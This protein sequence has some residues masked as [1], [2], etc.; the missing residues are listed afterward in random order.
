MR[1][2]HGRSVRAGSPR[3]PR[4]L[5]FALVVLATMP[6][7]GTGPRAEEASTSTSTSASVA[8]VQAQATL[9]QRPVLATTPAPRAAP[10]PAPIAAPAD[11]KDLP[12]W[13]DYRVRNHVA[14]LPLEARHFYRQGLLLHE[15]GKAEDA[16][17]Y[18]RGA[19]E[20]DPGFVAP[21]LTLASWLMLREPSQALLQYATVI[22]LAR[23][24]FLFQLATAGN[25]L[26]L[27]LVALF[28]G[29][30]G[31][32]LLVVALRNHELRHA[33]AER[34]ARRGD[35]ATARW[36]AWGLLLLPFACGLGLALPTLALL[37]L[38]RPSLR[39]A[40]RAVLFGL[41]AVVLALP[42]AAGSL[43]RLAV[44]LG[45]A[46]SPF[47]GVPLVAAETPTPERRAQLAA[48]AA[49]H[50]D[51]P[52]LQVAAAWTARR[53]GD[54][55]AAEAG[56]RR[57]L[58]LW[59]EDDRVLNNLGNV[60]AMQGRQ[61]EALELY[62]HAGRVNPANAAAPFN[63]SQI[64][65]QR[66]DYHAATDALSR[67]SA[68]DFDLV[69]T[70]QSQATDDGV[71]PLADEWIAPG[72]F[73]AALAPRPAAPTSRG[74]LPPPWAACVEC[75]GWGFGLAALLVTALALLL[76]G[77]LGRALPL[78]ACSNCGAVV[79]RRCARRRRETAL[80]P[81]CAAA[82][83]RADAPDFARVL[84]HNRR[85]QVRAR[86]RYLQTAVAL[87]VPGY[88]LLAYR[89]VMAP[90]LLLCAGGALLAL[91]FGEAAPFWYEARPSL[92][93]RHLPAAALT[94]AWLLLCAVSFLGYL[95]RR[96]RADADEA[97]AAAP[98]R[99]RIRLSNRDRS[100][101]AA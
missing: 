64:Y 13:L 48:L 72:S 87:L 1:L 32:G 88:G 25:A 93:S 54:L 90:V 24:D 16:V 70:Y 65:T 21:H 52:F 50:A 29:L 3:L 26:H 23:D 20:L 82:E 7:A 76:G 63:A 18:V 2:R 27:A 60:L 68:L 61:D 83:A 95:A 37:A 71:L 99:S 55:A 73:W 9:P 33:W 92:T 85:R 39:A 94:G 10:P 5:A 12:A 8:P 31:T 98:V 36:W 67:A 58:G 97:A 14:A 84:L 53:G 74:A 15:D 78:R 47:H 30:L 4:R 46:H 45:D 57:A 100:T 81:A 49:T 38:L 6:P 79:C 91:T 22:E 77:R 66:F 19:A 75:S 80:C 11:L 28:V 51:S 101:L 62:R 56:Y 42:W 86:R 34:L 17:R 44:P 40:E 89:R 41:L 35:P 96:A 59:P 69:K 43:E